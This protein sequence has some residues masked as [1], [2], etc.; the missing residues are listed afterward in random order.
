MFMPFIG[1]QFVDR[2]DSRKVL[3][4]FSVIVCA[5]QTLFSIGVSMRHFGVMLFGRALF[6]IGGEAISVIQASITSEWFKNKELAFA[7][8]LNICIARFGSVVSRN[9]TRERLH[10]YFTYFNLS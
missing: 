3:M 2:F 8:G 7:L 5:G 6:G 1:G 9:G 4:M 10:S